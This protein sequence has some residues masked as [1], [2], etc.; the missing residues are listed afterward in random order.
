MAGSETMIASTKNKKPIPKPLPKKTEPIPPVPN[1]KP[2]Q[3]AISI[4]KKISEP[5]LPPVAHQMNPNANNAANKVEER[6]AKERFMNA[7]ARFQ[8]S[9]STNSGQSR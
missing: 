6:A 7:L 2:M 8:I 4:E 1:S 9:T 3:N 5:M